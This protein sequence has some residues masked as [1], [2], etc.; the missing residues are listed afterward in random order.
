[1]VR[2]KD[3]NLPEFEK[4]V[5]KDFESK[6]GPE[7]SESQKEYCLS[8]AVIAAKISTITANILIQEFNDSMSKP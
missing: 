2:V 5:L 6:L 1:M 4:R 7:L 3:L 8:I